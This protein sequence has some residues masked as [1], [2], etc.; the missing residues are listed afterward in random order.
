MQ[1]RKRVWLVPLLLSLAIALLWAFPSFWYKREST[2]PITWFEEQSN[3][4]NCRFSSVPI[5]EVAEKLLV[6]DKTVNGDFVLPDGHFIRVFSA[7]RFAEKQNEIGLFM[8][9]PDRCWTEIGWRIE[10][11]EPETIEMKINT[12]SIE[13]ERRI[14][15]NS[16]HRELVY[17]G[18]L[19]AG[20]P[21]PYR[22]DHNLSIASRTEGK[23]NRA[24]RAATVRISDGHFWKR[25]W[26]SFAEGEELFGPKQFI[27]IST[28][29]EGD[30]LS[31]ADERLQRFLPKWLAAGDFSADKENWE[32]S[33]A[34]GKIVSSY[35][36]Q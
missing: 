7:K 15:T 6:A 24:L 36:P 2:A 13:F 28:E 12:A 18:G 8:H 33:K 1:L 4:E 29:I 9:T 27:R 32:R 31:E 35:S 10:P 11:S 17:F 20:K 21:L 34:E 3:V 16:V 5:S 25:L 14:F 19:V 26:Q 23:G 30:A 22:L